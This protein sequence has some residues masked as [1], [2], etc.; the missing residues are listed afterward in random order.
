MKKN[1]L[2]S[3]K[4]VIFIFFAF[5]FT[6][7]YSVF[8]GGTSGIVVDSESTSIPKA[9][10]GNVD[11]YAYTSEGDRDA[12]FLSWVEGEDFAPNAS[13]YGH[14]STNNDGSFSI[15]KLVWKSENPAFGKDADIRN[16]CIFTIYINTI[17]FSIY[18]IYR[19]YSRL[20]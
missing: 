12:D 13:Y 4:N 3:I 14:T 6:S 15:S 11:V 19:C 8:E 7:C 17:S 1:N 16:I 20:L 10:I 2:N 18:F 9:G 5:L